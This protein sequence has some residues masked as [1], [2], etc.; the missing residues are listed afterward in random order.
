[1]YLK[2]G[3]MTNWIIHIRYRKTVSTSRDKFISTAAHKLAIFRSSSKF[4]VLL[5]HK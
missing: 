5:M 2:L 1:M 4:Y 3:Y